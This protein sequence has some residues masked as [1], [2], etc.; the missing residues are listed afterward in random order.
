MHSN[1]L[2]TLRQILA[3]NIR[4]ETILSFLSEN[5]ENFD[6]KELKN[7]YLHY[8]G[9]I[10]AFDWIMEEEHLLISFFIDEDGIHLYSGP[11]PDLIVMPREFYDFLESE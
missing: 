9:A 3:D 5:I 7:N 1:S 11:F 8:I 10:V 2:D 4:S 6:P